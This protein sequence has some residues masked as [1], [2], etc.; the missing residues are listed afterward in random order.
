[1]YDVFAPR[2]N[3]KPQISWVSV[4]D[5]QAHAQIKKPIASAYS[6][7]TLTE[8]EPLVDDVTKKFMD[9][10]EDVGKSTDGIKCDM[11]VWMRLCKIFD[12]I[13]SPV[14]KYQDAFDVITYLTFSNTLGFIDAG[15]DIDDFT[16]SLD[17]NLD[18]LALVMIFETHR[19]TC[20]A[21]RCP[22]ADDYALDSLPRQTQSDYWHVCEEQHNLPSMGRK[23][24]PGTH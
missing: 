21:D 8:Y 7:T 9:R 10:L 5:P 2:I 1:M 17:K 14:L 12:M 18:Q 20:M 4:R 15:C 16:L 23:A 24:G 19:R 11:A 6:L 22:V 13:Y 3:G